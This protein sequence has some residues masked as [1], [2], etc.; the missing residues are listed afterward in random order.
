MTCSKCGKDK[1]IVS[2]EYDA[3][4]EHSK[5]KECF[6]ELE[7]KIIGGK[8]KL[9]DSIKGAPKPKHDDDD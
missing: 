1:P 2:V 5:C 6:Y 8:P 3:A 4:G 7:V 9:K